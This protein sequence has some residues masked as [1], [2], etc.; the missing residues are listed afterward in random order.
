MSFISRREALALR[1]PPVLD[2]ELLPK[3]ARR[4]D[5]IW[6]GRSCPMCGHGPRSVQGYAT[7]TVSERLGAFLSGDSAFPCVAVVCGHCGYTALVNLITAG[8][9]DAEGRPNG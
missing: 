6:A 5:S 2:A 4:I 7:L 8:I 9:L 3:I 1:H